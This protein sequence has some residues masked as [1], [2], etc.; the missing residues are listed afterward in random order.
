MWRCASVLALLGLLTSNACAATFS[1][2]TTKER[3][4]VI[5]LTG[6]ITTG[7][8]DRFVTIVKETNDASREVSGL[9]LN[10]PGGDLAEAARLA[11]AVRFSKIATIV[12]AKTTCA[13]ACFVV[14]AAGDQKYVG[15]GAQV[16][17]HGASTSGGQE[18]DDSKAA[19]IAMAKM[20]KELGVPPAIIGQM[21]VTPPDQMVWLSTSDL[22]GMGVT[23]VGKPIQTAGPLSLDNAP[24]Q[25][26]RS[27]EV[28]N[29]GQG[30]IA[31]LATPPPEGRTPQWSQ[32]V[33]AA[34]AQSKIQYGGTPNMKRSC[35]PELKLCTIA[36]F[37]K[38]SGGKDTMVRAAQDI[39]DQVVSRDICTFNFYGDVRQCFNWDTG[40]TSREMKNSSGEWLEISN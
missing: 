10:S 22:Q 39:N 23:M 2:F 14:F 30:A 36:I 38:D 33:D 11:D 13:S 7:D 37:F 5:V 40:V 15:Y 17:V 34:I 3:R 1:H 8:T 20:V 18:T 31:S 4:E 6:E 9:R 16:G 26:T 35:Q 25:Q 32:V 28:P 29:D 24:P 27:P 19:T 12:V 21:V